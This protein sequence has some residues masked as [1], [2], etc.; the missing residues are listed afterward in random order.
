MSLKF[1]REKF[2]WI[3]LCSVLLCMAGTVIVSL[4]DSKGTST[5]TAK[6]HAWGD[7]LCIISACFYAVYT[8]LI[9]KQLPDEVQDDEKAST[10]LFFG[11]LGLF[12]GVIFLPIML[13]LH[14]T[15]V[16]PLHNLSSLQYGLI[17]GK[18]MLF[19]LAVLVVYFF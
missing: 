8:T 3:K 19:S 1:L 7:V 14:F 2:T 13:I 12:N 4:S 17:I 5:A 16:E 11:Y 6:N 9:K 18:G 10:A 15:G